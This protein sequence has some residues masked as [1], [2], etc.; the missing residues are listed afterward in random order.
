MQERLNKQYIDSKINPI[1]EPMA[2]SL[3]QNL[4]SGQS[5]VSSNLILQANFMLSYL[6]KNYGNR[7]SVNEGERMELDFLRKEVAKLRDQIAG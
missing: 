6:K 7:P 3:F 5:P 1:I 2:F 4:E